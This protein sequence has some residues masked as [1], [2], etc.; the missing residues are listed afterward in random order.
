LGGGLQI[1]LSLQLLTTIVLRCFGIG[2]HLSLSCR[3]F[4]E[5]A[6]S[7]LLICLVLVKFLMGN[8]GGAD[9]FDVFIIIKVPVLVAEKHRLHQIILN[10][11][12]VLGVSHLVMHVIYRKTVDEL[13]GERRINSFPGIFLSVVNYFD[14]TILILDKTFLLQKYRYLDNTILISFKLVF[15]VVLSSFKLGT[16]RDES[17]PLFHWRMY[18]AALLVLS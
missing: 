9:E 17:H 5:K 6:K 7:I 4:G 8:A 3:L 18:R 14:A 11:T 16:T 15:V 13:F 2:F 1:R 10:V 12:L